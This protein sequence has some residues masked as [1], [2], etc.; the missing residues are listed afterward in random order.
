MKR[1]NTYHTVITAKDS[2]MSVN[3]REVW[4][5]R[6]LIGLFTKRNFSILYK[7]TILGPAWVVITPLLTSIV[8]TVVFGEMAGLSTAGVPK[9][10]FYLCSHSL[11]AFFS[12][13]LRKNSETFIT[14][15]NVFG[16]VYFPRL[17]VPIS[18]VLFSALQFLSI[19]S[20]FGFR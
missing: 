15:S 2:P 16:K 6:D 19:S 3:L 13:C 5:Y 20:E 11:W 10:L 17:T 4:K 8:Y 9:L 7:Q 18:T 14:N 1:E 12:E